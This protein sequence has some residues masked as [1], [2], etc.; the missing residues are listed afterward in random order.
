MGWIRLG[1]DNGLQPA[2]GRMAERQYS[3]S[4]L[5]LRIVSCS[6]ENLEQANTNPAADWASHSPTMAPNILC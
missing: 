2:H 3:C 1:R 4:L 5:A 6:L